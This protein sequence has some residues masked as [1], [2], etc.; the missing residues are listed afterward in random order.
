MS[1][2]AP[3]VRQKAKEYSS[4]KARFAVSGTALAFLAV[5]VFEVF[6]SDP[7]FEVLRR[8]FSRPDIPYIV[9][10]L[11]FCGLVL[12]PNRFFGSYR[13]DRKYGLSSMTAGAWLK[14]DLKA[15]T[16]NFLLS[17]ALIVVF[18]VNVSA[19][20]GTWWIISFFAWALFSLVFVFLYPK[21]ILPLFFRYIPISSE[22]LKAGIEE[23]GEKSGIKVRDVCR[24][25]FSR[26]TKK[27][28]A[29]VIGVWKTAKVILAD[30][31]T[32]N[33]TSDEVFMVTAHELGHYGKR[34][35]AKL[36]LFS[37]F[38]SFFGF[39][40]VF[41]VSNFIVHISGVP[42]LSDIRTLPVLFLLVYCFDFIALPL[43]NFFSRRL[44]RQ[45]DSFALD[46][47]PRPEVF[48][49]VMEKLADMNLSDTDP[50][51]LR[52]I[53]FHTHPAISER[54]NFARKKL[55]LSSRAAL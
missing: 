37:F 27:A 32:D 48:I 26:K 24:I 30:T 4:I 19:F 8:Y 44:E 21:V 51:L 36:L 53:F 39:W 11:V 35:V 13:I 33:F 17:L 16:L 50:P 29:A 45:A 38:L 43:R 41:E 52:K 14:D 46:V 18:Y 40:A 7:L 2:N 49:S 55:E 22:E 9:I 15:S 20:P 54:I 12:F 28:N 25:D 1:G 47:F 31:L 10:F 34:H 3:S 6:L 5:S 42:G 23:L